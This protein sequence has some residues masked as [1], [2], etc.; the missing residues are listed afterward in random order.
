MLTWIVQQVWTMCDFQY[1]ASCHIT[2]VLPVLRGAVKSFEYMLS[3]N[4]NGTNTSR[5]HFPAAGLP[6]CGGGGWDNGFQV[7]AA[8]WGLTTYT[9]MCKDIAE[10]RPPF[11][12]PEPI[13]DLCDFAARAEWL[14]E[15]LAPLQV[16]PVTGINAAWKVRFT[17]PCRHF[18]HLLNCIGEGFGNIQR[19]SQVC[20]NTADQFYKVTWQGKAECT[21]SYPPVVQMS[22]ANG[23]GDAAWG[24]IT[25]LLDNILLFMPNTMDNEGDPVSSAR[26]IVNIDP[27]ATAATAD[28]I[29]YLMI[30]SEGQRIKVFPTPPVAWDDG[31][32]FHRL[33]ASRGFVVSAR[34]LK[35]HGGVGWVHIENEAGAQP[36]LVTAQFSKPISKLKIESKSGHE[37]RL[38]AFPPAA[39]TVQ[40]LGLEQGDAVLISDP[41][42]PP[43]SFE[44][45]PLQGEASEQNYWGYHPESSR[46]Q[47]FRECC[48][49]F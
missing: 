10:H 2:Y 5:L 25:E 19:E 33:R 8:Q 36:V 24:N 30:Q 42:L 16:D 4:L 34:L 32:V 1:N 7:G 38:V 20:L 26:Q 37:V 21:F 11:S 17:E 31:A 23:R 3:H 45:Q 14:L 22:A 15:R 27:C 12:Q 9:S 35:Q 41:E 40:V 46:S 6:N 29:Q 49:E 43:D 44:I 48:A 18:D 28:S 13:G 47:A 39:N